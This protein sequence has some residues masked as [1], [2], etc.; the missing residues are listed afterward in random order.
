MFFQ[1][2]MRYL[3]LS[4]QQRIHYSCEGGLE[5]SVPRAD[6]FLSLGKPPDANW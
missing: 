5:K 2:K 4:K 1:Y 6:R 3:V